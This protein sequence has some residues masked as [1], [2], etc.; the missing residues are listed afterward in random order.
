MEMLIIERLEEAESSGSAI[1]DITETTEATG[2][3]FQVYKTLS[4]LEM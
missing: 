1:N 4:L 3:A 2:G